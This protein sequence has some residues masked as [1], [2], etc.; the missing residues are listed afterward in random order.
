[1]TPGGGGGR[2]GA[3][4][5]GEAGWRCDTGRVGVAL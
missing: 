4:T 5:S 3:V 1:M 2:S